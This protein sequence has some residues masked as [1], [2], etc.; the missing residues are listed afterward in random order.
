MID[1]SRIKDIIYKRKNG[2]NI[3]NDPEAIKS[4]KNEQS[5]DIINNAR[6][7]S[8]DKFGNYIIIPDIKRELIS[9]P[10]LIYNVRHE[11]NSTVYEMKGSIPIFGDVFFKLTFKGEEAILLL[12]E[13]VKREANGYQETY[14]EVI[15]SLATGE[16]GLPREIIFKNY[17]IKENPDNFGKNYTLYDYNNI[18]TRKVYLSLLSKE[19]NNIC[20]VDER[21]AFNKM[22]KTLKS[23][24]EYGKRVLSEFVERLKDRPGIFEIEKT[25]KYNKAINEV[26]LSSLDIATTKEDKEDFSNRQAYL[27]VLNARNEN[28][29][30]YIEEA[31]LRVD[32]EYVKKV[33]NNATENFNA[34]LEPSEEENDFVENINENKSP[35]TRRKLEKPI[36]KQGKGNDGPEENKTKEE[37]VNA[38]INKN[39]NKTPKGKKLKP[40]NGK[41]KNAKKK[42]KLSK[43]KLKKKE[44]KLTK[45]KSPQKAKGKVGG[46]LKKSKPKKKAKSKDSDLAARLLTIGFYNSPTV[47][48]EENFVHN[49]FKFL[50]NQEPQKEEKNYN[51]SNNSI[52]FNFEAFTVSRHEKVDKNK[53]TVDE[54]QNLAED[55]SSKNIKSTTTGIERNMANDFNFR[56]DNGAIEENSKI[57]KIVVYEPLRATNTPTPNTPFVEKIE[58]NIPHPIQPPT[59][60]PINDQI[61]GPVQDE[62]T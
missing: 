45:A 43:G 61:Q 50:S 38:I 29:D 8:Y 10:K 52:N 37:K 53:T 51:N 15:D 5:R 33:V 58:T 17:H 62:T 7:G 4:C 2:E 57:E 41:K 21:S 44:K 26:L 27:Q 22:V 60:N 35:K 46:G 34:G 40:S 59:T 55:L 20:Q 31:N 23:S 16:N 14:D 48:E 32:E 54:K 39:K 49:K 19:L 11:N 36:L 56:I 30:N 3:V 12:T 1:N 18:L 24:G 13:T 28:I 6:L 42:K 47:K 25:D 9:M